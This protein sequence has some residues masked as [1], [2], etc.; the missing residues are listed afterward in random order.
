[1]PVRVARKWHE[2]WTRDDLTVSNLDHDRWLPSGPGSAFAALAAEPAEL[3][4][5]P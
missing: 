1:V 2:V 4:G 3:R 5:V